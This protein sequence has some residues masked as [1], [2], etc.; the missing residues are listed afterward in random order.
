MTATDFR[1]QFADLAPNRGT[2]G[3]EIDSV[4]GWWLTE[5]GRRR[6][7]QTDPW[8]P[9]DECDVLIAVTLLYMLNELGPV[10][11]RDVFSKVAWKLRMADNDLREALM[12]A[13]Y[14][15]LVHHLLR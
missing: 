6:R 13:A 7:S 9:S 12:Q 11:I 3:F 10:P 4:G 5:A 15:L 14:S 1:A 8:R 2:F